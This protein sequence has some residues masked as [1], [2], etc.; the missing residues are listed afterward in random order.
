MALASATYGG[1]GYRTDV[2]N[3]GAAGPGGSA[4]GFP[5]FLMDLAKRRAQTQARK[6]QLDLEGQQTALYQARQAGRR[7]R[8]VDRPRPTLQD[9]NRMMAENA[10]AI[11]EAQ[12]RQAQARTLTERG[13]QRYIFGL[14]YA[15]GPNTTQFDISKMTGAQ[16]QAYLPQAAGL[17][18]TPTAEEAGRL[19][20]ATGSAAN[21]VEIEKA[22]RWAKMM[23]VAPGALF[24]PSPMMRPPS[25]GKGDEEE[26]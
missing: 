8:F 25:R 22:I 17:S 1:G 12:G 18:E 15:G 6:D 11:A 7:P 14:G 21:D 9:N 20:R 24:N 2:S 10:A 13:P 16:R 19:T 3:Q 23:G 5:A 26:G 4:G